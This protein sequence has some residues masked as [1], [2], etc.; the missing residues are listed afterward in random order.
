MIGSRNF[1]VGMFCIVVVLIVGV[2]FID[3]TNGAANSQ[4]TSANQAVA[5]ARTGDAAQKIAS[6]K[7]ETKKYLSMEDAFNRGVSFLIQ[8]FLIAAIFEA[9][10]SRLFDWRRF[11]ENFEGKGIKT[12]I[13]LSSATAFSWASGYY[14]INELFYAMEL[15]ETSK[16]SL[17]TYKVLDGVTTGLIIGGGSSAIFELLAKLQLRD[18]KARQA[19]AQRAVHGAVANNGVPRKLDRNKNLFQQT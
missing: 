19:M 15:K 16:Y 2:M 3:G 17:L 18:P 7:L 5:A 9:A 10:L 4:V 1:Y 14:A 11:A 8:L 13:V 12:I 6:P